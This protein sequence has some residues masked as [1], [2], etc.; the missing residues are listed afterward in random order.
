MIEHILN[1]LSGLPP[2]LIIIIIASLPIVE[3]RGAIPIAVLTYHLP[4]LEAYVLAV[5]GNLI[6]ILPILLLLTPIHNLLAKIPV[7][8]KFFTWFFER[9]RKRATQVE[10]YGAIGLSL[11]VAIPLPVTGAWTGSVA[12]ILFNIRRR[13]ALPAIIVGVLLAGIIVLTI[14]VGIDKIF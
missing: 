11:F 14:S 4:P 6:P 3:L 9:T 5:I 2:Q 13:Y 7:F 10:K 8:D 12:A 1:F